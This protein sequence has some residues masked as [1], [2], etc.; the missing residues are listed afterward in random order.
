MHQQPYQKATL[1]WVC[2][3][4]VLCLV[5]LN[6]CS[7]QAV[8]RVCRELNRKQ[9]INAESN[10]RTA[11]VCVQN[12]SFGTHVI[13]THRSVYLFGTYTQEICLYCCVE[14]GKSRNQTFCLTRYAFLHATPPPSPL[15]PPPSTGPTRYVQG[16]RAMYM[17]C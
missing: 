15:P 1:C 12:R 7:A 17:L 3:L 13:C 11:S 16:S 9:T 8:S 4:A 2:G 14:C 5:S 10:E 6:V